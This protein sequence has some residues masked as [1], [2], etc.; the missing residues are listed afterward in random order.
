MFWSADV[1]TS[2]RVGFMR[3]SLKKKRCKP[4]GANFKAPYRLWKPWH[5]RV[6]EHFQRENAGN[7]IIRDWGGSSGGPCGSGG[8]YN[9]K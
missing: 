3:K 6:L 8:G 1:E 7:S 9:V 2:R 4:F 5:L